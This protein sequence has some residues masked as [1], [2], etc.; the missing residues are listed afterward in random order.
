[1]QT[2]S[3][4]E[5][6]QSQFKPAIATI[7]MAVMARFYLAVADYGRAHYYWGRPTNITEWVL[8]L[9]L[10]IVAAFAFGR[11]GRHTFNR[12]I[13]FL[14]SMLGGGLA[15]AHCDD[16]GAI[17]GGLFSIPIALTVALRTDRQ[18]IKLMI[19]SLCAC[20]A[21]ALA[22]WA[23]WPSIGRLFSSHAALYTVTLICVSVLV[24]W[25]LSH[26]LE[27]QPPKKSWL[28]TTILFSYIFLLVSWAN[29][30][31]HNSVR[32]WAAT[33]MVQGGMYVHQLQPKSFL[34]RVILGEIRVGIVDNNGLEKV[35]PKDV[36]LLKHFPELGRLY[37]ANSSRITD[38]DLVHLEHLPWL[39]RLRLENTGVTERALSHL[40]IRLVELELLGTPVT[41]LGVER[42]CRL[43][44]LSKIRLDQ[45]RAS[46]HSISLLLRAHPQLRDLRLDGAE[47]GTKS[48]AAFS[49]LKTLQKLS[50]RG[51]RLNDNL[52]VVLQQLP[53]NLT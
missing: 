28:R 3:T 41:D 53:L 16:Y 12:P 37:L 48:I 35:D 20:C 19:R 17:Y 14:M 6:K 26:R 52:T 11:I 18:L 45:C 49:K 15:A 44:Y 27:R 34:S 46:D 38:D 39:E 2:Q 4:D 50:L 21:I 32:L 8:L 25:K 22:T 30:F 10:V 5:T 47:V 9:T 42:L 33:R 7:V 40:R 29:I 31:T 1:M 43:P 24:L 23:R 51:G 13:G 36:K